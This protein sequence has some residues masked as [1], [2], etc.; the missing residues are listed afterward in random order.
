[1]QFL[2]NV[3][4]AELSLLKM[5]RIPKQK[6]ELSVKIL[7]NINVR[8]DLKIIEIIML[9][10]LSFTIKTLKR[11]RNLKKSKYIKEV[12]CLIF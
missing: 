5:Y 1:M 9:K 6:L 11:T 10:Q 4:I 2:L 3:V 8:Q 12:M 7:V